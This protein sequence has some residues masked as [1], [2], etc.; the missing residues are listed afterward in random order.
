MN[1]V[2]IDGINYVPKQEAEE[3]PVEIFRIGIGI[4]THNRNK[5]CQK[6]LEQITKLTPNAKIV[7]VDDASTTPFLGATFRFEN[8]VGI[9]RAKNKCL[10][11]LDGCEH[12]FLFDD[13]CYPLVENWWKP[14]VDSPEPHLMYLF[15]K[16]S[17][18]LICENAHVIFDDGYLRAESHPRGCMLYFEKRVLDVVGGFDTDFNVWGNEHVELS[19]RI[20]NAGLTTFKFADVS[21][22]HDLIYSADEANAI[23]RSVD[24]KKRLEYL[25]KNKRLLEEKINNCGYCEY[26]EKKDVVLTVFFNSQP[27]PQR[28]VSWAAD[29]LLL[30]PL[31]DSCKLNAAELVIINDCFDFGENAPCGINPLWQRWISYYQYLRAHKEIDKVFLVDAT[32]VEMLKNPFPLMEDKIYVGSE[33]SYVGTNTW[34]I[35]NHKKPN[36]VEFIENNKNKVLLNA[37][38]L[39]GK[40]EDILEICHKMVALWATNQSCKENSNSMSDMALFNKVCYS[41]GNKILFGD[42][43]NTEFKKKETNDFS[44]FRHK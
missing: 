25:E 40:R 29:T 43:I 15:Y 5:E 13:D 35:A 37:G 14:Y 2:I 24:T 19:N 3:T 34:L 33:P 4:T 17:N 16:F 18:G 9:S 28:K 12:I 36:E 39:G 7:V 8:N 11:L 44:W 1:E 38:L 6:C 41:M 31:I 26:R 10:E 22:S 42:S 23:T 30:K 21:G 27:D 20:F 32:D